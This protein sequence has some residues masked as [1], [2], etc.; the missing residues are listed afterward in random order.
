VMGALTDEPP[1]GTPDSVKLRLNRL[2]RFNG[3]FETLVARQR[4]WCI[5]DEEL[6]R[7]TRAKWSTVLRERYRKML[8]PF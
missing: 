1:R 6:R 7:K 2:R 4:R 5:P 8:L 3:A